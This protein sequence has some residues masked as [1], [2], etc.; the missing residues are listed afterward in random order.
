MMKMLKFEIKNFR[1][2]KNQT[3]EFGEKITIIACQIA[4]AKLL[5]RLA[6][7]GGG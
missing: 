5:R 7:R 6:R 4:N 1:H 2:I 3:I